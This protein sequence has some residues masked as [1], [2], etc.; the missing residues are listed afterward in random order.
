[1]GEEKRRCIFPLY[2]VKNITRSL[3]FHF[4][5]LCVKDPAKSYLLILHRFR[6]TE[7]KFHLDMVCVCC[8]LEMG[9]AFSEKASAALL[10]NGGY[11]KICTCICVISHLLIPFH[12]RLALIIKAFKEMI[13]PYKSQIISG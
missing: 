8:F 3:T 11:V 2:S 5:S 9:G 6:V 13:K 10:V 7:K 1:M 4:E 12:S